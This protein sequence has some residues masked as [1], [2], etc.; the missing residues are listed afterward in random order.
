MFDRNLFNYY[1][2]E[3]GQTKTTVSAHLGIDPATLYRKSHGTS[4]FTR[5]EIQKLKEFLRL[6]NEQA[7]SVFFAQK[8]TE[9]QVEEE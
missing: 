1:M 7:M 5:D 8:L 9:T 3:A 4:E 6:T 2:A